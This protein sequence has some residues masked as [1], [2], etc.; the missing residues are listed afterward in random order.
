MSFLKLKPFLKDYYFYILLI[1]ICLVVTSL[2]VLS[3]GDIIKHILNKGVN[4]EYFYTNINIFLLTLSLV[5]CFSSFLR[6][7]CMNYLCFN[8]LNHLKQAAFKSLLNYKI[9]YLEINDS[10]MIVNSIN[11][12]L[13]Q[14][15]QTIS[16]TIAF[17]MRNIIV[18]I[19]SI[20]MLI[21]TSPKLSMIVI[22]L[23]I[24]LILPIIRQSKLLRMQNKNFEDK[25][26]YSFSWMIEMM[27]NMK[28]VLGFNLTD[29]IIVELKNID[30][31]NFESFKKYLINKSFIIAMSMFFAINVINFFIYLKIN[32]HEF[33][34]ISDGNY[35]AFIFYSGL[36]AVSLSAL[37]EMHGE[38]TKGIVAID[39]L[40]GY[41][42]LKNDNLD[43][44]INID[45][46]IKSIEFKNIW[47]VYPNRK[48]T[49][50]LN[51]FNLSIKD[52][53]FV[54]IQGPSGFG[55]STLFQL[56]LGFYDSYQGD[57]LINN[58]SIKS[59]N[60]KDIRKKIVMV[61]Q[62]PIIFTG[63]LKYNLVFENE[64]NIDDNKIIDYINQIGLDD[65][66]NKIK[67]NINNEI[68]NKGLMISGGEK[69]KIAILRA[70]FKKPEVL[71]LDEPTSAL[72]QQSIKK[73]TDTISLNMKDK[74][75]VYISHDDSI[76]KY[77]QKVIILK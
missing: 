5:F 28:Q 2:C 32:F 58:I 62:S 47:F 26:S 6:S 11:S 59:I 68:G 52:S 24:L 9:E 63:T 21:V 72:D 51:N 41:I 20:F 44:N 29:K 36:A 46:P 16:N 57:I 49:I 38:I 45:Q 25:K 67:N 70:L 17:S 7:F 10:S 50:V 8:L 53:S 54:G 64:N 55:K 40:F 19:G 75:V 69:Q 34:S 42:D 74:I 61:E 22:F 18:A 73:V 71:L 13:S 65:L 33:Y 1:I 4:E 30:T 76:K 35:A 39:R 3:F 23:M 60:K 66:F 31:N 14:I 77:I 12:D 37:S 56:L 48:D 27:N 43:V 15:S